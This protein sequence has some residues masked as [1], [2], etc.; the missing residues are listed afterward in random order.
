MG[1]P[2]PEKAADE[3]QNVTLLSLTKEGGKLMARGFQKKISSSSSAAGGSGGEGGGG[4]DRVVICVSGLIAANRPFSK[5]DICHLFPF[6][7]LS[8]TSM[9]SYCSICL[10]GSVCLPASI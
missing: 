7:P 1:G 4:H 3:F 2:Q 10:P 8:A 6:L 5:T 9:V